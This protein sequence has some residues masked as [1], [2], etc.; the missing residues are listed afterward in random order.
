M[1]IEARAHNPSMF[2]RCEP[3]PFPP[4]CPLAGLQVAADLAEQILAVTPTHRNGLFLQHLTPPKAAAR[5]AR[6]LLLGQRP[7]RFDHQGVRVRREGE[8]YQDNGVRVLYP[9]VAESPSGR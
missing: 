2:A 6:G 9:T 7:G 8:E 3:P 5:L 4:L 1:R